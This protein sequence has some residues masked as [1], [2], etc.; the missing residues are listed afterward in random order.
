MGVDDYSPKVLLALLLLV[1]GPAVAAI[2]LLAASIA[3]QRHEV[4]VAWSSIYDETTGLRNREFFLERLDLQCQ[5]GRDLAEYRVGVILL[6]VEE[7]QDGQKPQATDD[8]SSGA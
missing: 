3:Q 6:T 4:L 8:R 1:C 5:L 2:G 7:K